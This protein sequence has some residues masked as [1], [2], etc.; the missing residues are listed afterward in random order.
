VAITAEQLL[1]I[2]GLIIGPSSLVGVLVKRWADDRAESRAAETKAQADQAKALAD[3]WAR[4][5]D[6]AEKREVAANDRTDRSIASI[7][8]LTSALTELTNTNKLVLKEIKYANAGRDTPRS[9]PHA[10]TRRD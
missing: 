5:V 6:A 3:A 7:A 2:L 10:D 9:G 8:Q 4:L 1:A